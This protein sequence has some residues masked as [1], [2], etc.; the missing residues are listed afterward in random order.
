MQSR[1]PVEQN[2]N[3]GRGWQAASGTTYMLYSPLALGL[4][5]E[6]GLEPQGSQEFPSLASLRQ[7]VVRWVQ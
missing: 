1:T 6:G 4:G 7:V 5:D 3:R 2:I